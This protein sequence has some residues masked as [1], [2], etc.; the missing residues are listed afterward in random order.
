MFVCVRVSYFASALTVLT[1]DFNQIIYYRTRRTRLR[2]IETKIF[3]INYKATPAAQQ[4]RTG[5]S[6]GI[7]KNL[8]FSYNLHRQSQRRRRHRLTSATRL[9]LCPLSALH[10]RL[11]LSLALLSRLWALGYSVSRCALLASLPALL[12]TLPNLLGPPC[13]TYTNKYVHIHTYIL[14]GN[15]CG[16]TLPLC[17]LL[18]ALSCSFVL[19]RSI[20]FRFAVS[21][22]AAAAVAVAALLPNCLLLS[23]T[24]AYKHTHMCGCIWLYILFVFVLLMFSTFASLN[25]FSARCIWLRSTSLPAALPQLSVLFACFIPHIFVAAAAAAGNQFVWLCR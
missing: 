8:L 9:G 10:N 22:S 13:V 21:A 5:S 12:S 15:L 16:T 1:D 20:A 25:A 6:S 19:F 4:Q 23:A 18:C 24:L 17:I 2:L 3:L 11:S 7:S 14:T